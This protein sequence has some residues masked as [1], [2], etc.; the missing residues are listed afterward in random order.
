MYHGEESPGKWD[1]NAQIGGA[2]VKLIGGGCALADAVM[3][4]DSSIHK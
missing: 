1:P 2:E 3:R 4:L